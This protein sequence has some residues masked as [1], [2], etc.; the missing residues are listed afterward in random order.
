MKFSI[1]WLPAAIILASISACV[2]KPFPPTGVTGTTGTTGMTGTTGSTGTSCSPDTVYF[3]NTVL[4]IIQTNCAKS[5]CH[6][7]IT[8]IEEFNLSSYSGIMRSRLVVAGDTSDSYLYYSLVTAN[9]KA[10]MPPS[11]AAPLGASQIQYIVTW[12]LQGAQ[13]NTCTSSLCDTS[14]IS[15]A[16]IIE[17][18]LNSSCYGCHSTANAANSGAG[19]DLQNFNKLLVFANNGQLVCDI[20]QSTGCN[21][22]PLGGSK[23]S[24]CEIAQITQW[25]KD[26]APDN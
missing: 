15:Y 16:A 7:S 4:P 19:D 24:S 20:N 10:I 3:T 11:P 5:G 1:S 2:H 9:P 21:A 22:M 13:N 6:D 17:P 14:N 26:G 18:I 25:V 23:L 12:I 8:H